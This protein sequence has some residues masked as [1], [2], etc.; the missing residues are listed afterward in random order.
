MPPEVSVVIPTFNRSNYVRLAIQSVLDQTFEDFEIIVV[1]DASTDN[2]AEVIE[3]FDDERIRTIHHRRNQGGS[4]ARNTGIRCSKGEFIAF[5]DDDDLW[6]KNKLER[7]LDL[8]YKSNGTS[9]V[10][11]HVK[12]VNENG[13]TISFYMPSFRGNILLIL[14]KK[15]Y[16][17]S[18]SSVL[19]RK[20]C[21][22][23][24]G[25]FDE[26]LQ[27]AQDYDMWIRLAKHYEFDYVNG[28]LAIYRIH[29]RRITSN[30]YAKVQAEEYMFRKFSTDLNSHPNCREVLGCWHYRLGRA[31]CECGEISKGRKEFLKATSDNPRS[32]IYSLRLFACFFGLPIHD[33]LVRLL[34]YG[35]PQSIKSEV[36]L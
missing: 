30:P 4:A 6:M 12:L 2:T 7:Q 35:L 28:P 31:Y 19:V 34:K 18:C 10:Y 23:K 36:T 26:N 5:L 22:S 17:G 3:K 9:I 11:T 21:F 15:N 16:V 29:Q 20:E 1:D 27:A 13:E 24:V 25:L 32:I 8:I 33:A 14:L